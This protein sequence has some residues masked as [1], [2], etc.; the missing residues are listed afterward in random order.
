MITESIYSRLGD[1]D[2]FPWSSSIRAITS[3]SPSLA[4]FTLGRWDQRGIILFSHYVNEWVAESLERGALSPEAAVAFG[5]LSPAG[6]ESALNAAL[7]G[8]KR[9]STVHPIAETAIGI[10]SDHCQRLAPI[11]SRI[12]L[13]KTLREWGEK[14]HVAALPQDIQQFLEGIDHTDEVEQPRVE[15]PRIPI[16]IRQARSAPKAEEPCP[17][18]N[19]DSWLAGSLRSAAE[20]IER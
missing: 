6:N 2:H 7:S 8:A 4:A 9:L 1:S 15:E 17:I 19:P 13:L 18:P 3:L 12:S 20:Y 5:V 10:I 11:D 14:N 16:V